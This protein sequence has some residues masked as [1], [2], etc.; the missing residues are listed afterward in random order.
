MTGK[1]LLEGKR[2]LIVD[3]E[4]D[5]LEILESL[6]PMCKIQKA[7]SF[8]SA[9]KTAGVAAF[10]YS[11]PGYHGC[12]R[13]GLLETGKGKDIIAVMLTPTPS[14]WRTRSGPIKRGRPP[15]SQ[16]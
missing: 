3:D 16:G 6:L 12:E 5:I 10:R 13:Y 11:H 14:R 4:P 9:K 15:T 2:V 7:T 1:D 8:E